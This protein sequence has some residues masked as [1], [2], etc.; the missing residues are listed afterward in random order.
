MKKISNS[1]VKN[2]VPEKSA[3]KPQKS[4]FD[5]SDDIISNL[6]EK[7]R[8]ISEQAKKSSLMEN[9]FSGLT[10][11]STSDSRRTNELASTQSKVE[12]NPTKSSHQSLNLLTKSDSIF[13]VQSTTSTT[14]YS[15]TTVVSVSRESRRGR[16]PSTGLLDPLGL[17]GSDQKTD[18]KFFS[19]FLTIF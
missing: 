15:P 9:L 1:T 14:G 12:L 13:S 3:K 11:K 17:L 6:T 19:I 2:I 4:L 8:P 5:D 16:R 10:N 7:P 18:V